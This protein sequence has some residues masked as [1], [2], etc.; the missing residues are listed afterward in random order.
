VAAGVESKRAP[1]ASSPKF[2]RIN[3]GMGNGFLGNRPGQ[4]VDRL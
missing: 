3:L 4:F 1:M 2:D